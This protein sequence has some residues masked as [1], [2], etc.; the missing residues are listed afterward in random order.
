MSKYVCTKY[1]QARIN[2]QIKNF[3]PGDRCE[4]A[5]KDIFPDNCFRLIAGSK[6]TTSKK[7]DQ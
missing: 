7:E 2:G 6:V 5:A 1:C 4:F 3:K